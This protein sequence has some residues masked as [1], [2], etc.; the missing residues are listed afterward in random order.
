MI[1]RH[2][3]LASR[4]EGRLSASNFEWA[5]APTPPL[6]D[7]QILVRTVHLSLDPTNRGWTNAS[8]TYLP[9]LTLGDVMRGF[10]VGIV[11]ES[12]NP[13]FTQ[14]QL[15]QGMTGWQEYVVSEGRGFARVT[16]VPGLP[17]T[18]YLGLLGHIGA[19]AYF[20]LLDVG[21]PQ[22]GE[23]V[24][25][26]AAAGAVGSLVGQI[27]KIH[28]CRVI[29]IAGGPEK[30]KWLVEDLGFDAAIDYKR[31]PVAP[32][33]RVLS[34]PGIDVGFEN[35]G[36]EIL[37]AILANL[38]LRGR[39]VL[40]GMIAQYNEALPP[41]G[42]RFLGNLLVKR[43]RM[44]GFIVLDYA[45]RFAEATSKLVEWHLAGKLKYRVDVV[46]GLENAPMA[47]N[48]LFDGTNAGKLIVRVSEEP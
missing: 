25:V 42:P 10:G 40:C 19:T 5:E 15:V 14:G 8:A 23:T 33:V 36:G 7:G 22:S 18:A 45:A 34:R 41:P 20:G 38:N 31:E 27:A 21:R 29:G 35:V 39:I 30:C 28:G 46:E 1:N 11:E 13:A 6:L 2:W 43:G 44:E 48:K 17:F 9:P 3:R 32:R 4:P 24:V 12:K 26:S 16:P 37:D 47:L